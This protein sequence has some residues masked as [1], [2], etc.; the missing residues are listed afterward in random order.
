[1]MRIKAGERQEAV[2]PGP[3]RA[4]AAG[5]PLYFTAQARAAGKGAGAMGSVWLRTRKNNHSRLPKGKPS[6]TD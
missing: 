1:M 4:E 3:R 2:L 5:C 6:L